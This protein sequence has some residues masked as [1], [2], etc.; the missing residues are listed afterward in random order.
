MQRRT[1]VRQSA[2]WG[3]EFPGRE[4]QA[5]RTL[6]IDLTPSALERI[7]EVAPE[8]VAA[9]ERNHEA[10]MRTNQRM[11]SRLLL[12]SDMASTIRPTSRS[13]AAPSTRA[14]SA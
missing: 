3:W 1:L 5:L 4:R 14:R 11:T 9:G 7:E 8:G 2:E 6:D 10:G 13:L 12:G